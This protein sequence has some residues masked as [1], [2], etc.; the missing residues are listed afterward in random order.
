MNEF[1]P[2]LAAL[3][4]LLE[5]L[6]EYLP[7]SSTGHLIL[8]GHL[9]GFNGEMAITVEIC[10]QLG[11]V[12]AVVV[13]EREKI[14]TLLSL[15]YIQQ[16]ELRPS[17]SSPDSSSAS[18]SWT[19]R[20]QQSAK[21][22]H[23]LWFIIG[24]GAAFLP[25]AFVGFLAHDW[26]EKNLFSPKVVAVSLIVGGIIIFIVETWPKVVR[27]TT[28]ENIP[29]RSAIGVGIAQCVALIP[30][31]SRSGSTIVGGLLLGLDRKIATEFSFFLAL[32]TMFAATGYKLL[33]SYHLFTADDVFPL[34]I[35]MVVS[36]IVAWVVIASFL[37][38]VK[39][40]TLKVFAYYRIALGV[41]LLALL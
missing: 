17:T 40:H 12:L 16:R 14:K 9:L 41:A 20:L 36:F 29:V 27:I 6:T 2:G 37:T 3:L 31:M 23:H 28:L 21:K 10:I 22:H 5:G 18:Q 11:A 24:L 35:G 25:A 38:Y 34:F 33:Q 39:R 15:A 32:P 19:S 30:G 8:L 26:I 7:V 4:G 13:Y 1:S